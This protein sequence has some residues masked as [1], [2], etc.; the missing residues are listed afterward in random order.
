[1]RWLCTLAAA[2]VSLIFA[3]AAFALESS[4]CIGGDAKARHPGK[5]ADERRSDHGDRA[6]LLAAKRLRRFL[7]D[8]SVRAA[9]LQ[10]SLAARFDIGSSNTAP[11]QDVHAYWS[12][13]DLS[14]WE[15]VPDSVYAGGYVLGT[16]THLGLVFAG[17][18]RSAAGVA[19]ACP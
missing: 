16:T 12:K 1:M 19:N 18:T 6:E 9:N 7:S 2:V 3:S 10:L 5:R 15:L 8:L 13:A 17:R 4:R 11:S 14:G